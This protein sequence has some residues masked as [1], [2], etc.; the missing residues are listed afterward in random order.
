MCSRL[1]QWG[2]SI[3][4]PNLRLDMQGRR[5]YHLRAEHNTP[6]LGIIYWGHTGRPTPGWSGVCCVSQRNSGVLFDSLF[7][8]EHVWFYC[9]HFHLILP[10][11]TLLG[12]RAV[13]EMTPKMCF[14]NT[15]GINCVTR[16]LNGHIKLPFFLGESGHVL[17]IIS[18]L[19]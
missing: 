14:G 1:W 13:E 9:H 2:E 12:T 8:M 4:E 15:F 3:L 10:V 19:C 6:K 5:M 17:K 7:Q 18:R 16:S 11:P